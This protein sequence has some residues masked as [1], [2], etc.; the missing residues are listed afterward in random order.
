MKISKKKGLFKY[1]ID[2]IKI[3]WN[4]I[5]SLFYKSKDL[6]KLQKQ[7]IKLIKQQYTSGNLD[8]L[9]TSNK[10]RN[11]MS[12]EIYNQVI[13]LFEEELNKLLINNLRLRM[14]TSDPN[15]Y[16][17]RYILNQYKSKTSPENFAIAEKKLDSL[18]EQI[19]KK[20]I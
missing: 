10:I 9:E 18:I 5:F 15:L 12:G 8:P 7:K 1:S 20:N 13:K 11:I 2:S 6:N 4:K 14:N 19:N 16:K 3:E 17:F